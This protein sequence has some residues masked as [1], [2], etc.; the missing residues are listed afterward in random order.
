MLVE[1][2]VSKSSRHKGFREQGPFQGCLEKQG[3]FVLYLANMLRASIDS[4]ISKGATLN[5]MLF[6]CHYRAG[7]LSEGCGF[8]SYRITVISCS[9]LPLEACLLKYR[10][11]ILLWYEWPVRP[12][13]QAANC[14]SL[15][16]WTSAVKLDWPIQSDLGVY[17]NSCHTNCELCMCRLGKLSSRLLFFS[18]LFTPCHPKTKS[19]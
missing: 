2:V 13:G 1:G 7:S 12:W 16:R 17:S 15:A 10:S 9:L 14:K 11:A 19:I 4:F 18:R 8:G 5:V 6:G 3:R